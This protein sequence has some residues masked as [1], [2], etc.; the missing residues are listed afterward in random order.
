MDAAHEEPDHA[1]I[2]VSVSAHATGA[3]LQEE[4]AERPSDADQQGGAASEQELVGEQV[5]EQWE[6]QEGVEEQQEE[7][8]QDTDEQPQTT[9]QLQQTE[10][11]QSVAQPRQR[12][13]KGRGKTS[14]AGQ[15]V[16]AQPKKSKY[17][18]KRFWLT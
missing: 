13:K 14:L 10:Q 6:E 4:A 18:G 8:L 7:Q 3:A 15:G 16:Q 11:P 2:S 9:E 17:T 12:R 1:P 5:E